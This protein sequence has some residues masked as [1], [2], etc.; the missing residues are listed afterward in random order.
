M[1]DRYFIGLAT[2]WASVLG[3][4]GLLRLIRHWSQRPRIPLTFPLP[5]CRDLGPIGGGN[6]VRQLGHLTPHR[7]TSGLEW[8]ESERSPLASTQRVRR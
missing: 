3:P 4:Y 2:G 6:C 8:P 7:N 5:E 1:I